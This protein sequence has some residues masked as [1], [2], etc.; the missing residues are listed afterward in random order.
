MT[1]HYKLREGAAESLLVLAFVLA[2]VPVR[3]WLEKRFHKLFAREAAIYR[4]VLTRIGAQAGNYKQLPELLRF[5]EA[6]TARDLGLKR[7]Q[8]YAWRYQDEATGRER[9]EEPSLTARDPALEE[10]ILKAAVDLGSDVLEADAALSAAGF[11]SAYVLRREEKTLGLMLVAAAPG[12]L[13]TDVRSILEVLAGQVAIAL[14]DYRLIEENVRL[15]RELAQG[16]RLAALGQM[17][18]TVAHEVK[19]PLSA[20]KS[21]AQVMREDEHLSREYTRDLDLIVGETDR[22]NRSVTQLL[23]FARHAPPAGAPAF[24]DELART[25]VELFRLE[26]KG[27]RIQLRFHSETHELLDGAQVSAVRDALSNLLL[28]AI[29]ATPA[30][31]A[32]AVEVYAQAGSAS[33]SRSS[34]PSNAARDSDLPSSASASKRRA[35]R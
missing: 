31:G 2:A 13:T 28:N 20:I 34:R 23:N 24:T 15:E 16:E 29:Q 33:G 35:E 17:A 27:R 21:I 25:V 26:A 5:I 30:E 1:A 6:Q 10:R 32:V 8:F 22:L 18:A 12:A 14:E 19:N 11:E 7:V 9:V 3:A 4:D